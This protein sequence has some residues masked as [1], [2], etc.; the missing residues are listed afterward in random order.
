MKKT[1]ILPALAAIAA[2]VF[3][4]AAPAVAEAPTRA[5]G[6]GE[7]S[8]LQVASEQPLDHATAQVI[9]TESNGSTTVSLKVQGVDHSAVGR[10][11]GTHVHVGVC[12]EGDGLA[13]GGHYNASGGQ[14]ISSST[15]VWLDFTVEDNGTGSSTATVPFVIPAGGANCV[16]IHELPTNPTTGAA[17][18]RW[19]C[20]LVPF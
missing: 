7:L 11:F 3:S 20:I 1:T 12:V 9:A 8:D 13:A 16:V 15:E 14:V 6:A 5:R 19:A 10:T 18:P 17:G 4:V 2:F